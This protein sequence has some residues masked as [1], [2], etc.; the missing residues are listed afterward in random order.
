MATSSQ[1]I[2]ELHR[3]QQSEIAT[4]RNEIERLRRNEKRLKATQL[5][6]PLRSAPQR[7]VAVVDPYE[8]EDE[9]VL[10]PLTPPITLAREMGKAIVEE[11]KAMTLEAR[12]L[13]RS[14]AANPQAEIEAS[15]LGAMDALPDD[16]QRKLEQLRRRYEKRFATLGEQMAKRMISGVVSNSTAQL[17][18]GLHKMA[19]R[20]SVQSSLAEP[21]TRAVVEAAAQACTALIKRIPEKYL[22]EVQTAVMSAITTGSGLNRLVP[23]LTKRYKGDARHAKL[24]ALDQVRK[25][26]ANVNAARLQALGVEEYVWIHVGG[27]RYPRELHQRYNGRRFRYDDPP[28]IDKHTKERGKPGDLI[29]CRCVARPVLQFAKMRSTA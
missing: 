1:R 6:Q 18:I 8:K 14:L 10:A 19:E 27:E 11:L 12:A 3:R 26:S 29:N 23:Y 15:D 4:Q 5:R 17:N 22:G 25:V 21:R 13:V 24:V 2:D 28:I 7:R 20:M 16:A 9:K